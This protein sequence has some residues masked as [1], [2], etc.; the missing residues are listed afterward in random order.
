MKI[1]HASGVNEKEAIK[2]LLD[3]YRNTPHSSTGVAPS[4]MLFRDGMQ[5]IFPRQSASDREIQSARQRELEKKKSS[6]TKVNAGKF[7]IPSDFAVGD[8]VLVRNYQKT[9]KFEPTFL[10]DLY[11]VVEISEN[12]Q[13]LTLEDFTNGATLKRHPDDVK[14]YGGSAQQQLHNE[15]QQPSEQEVLK[16]Y[17]GRLSQVFQDYEDTFGNDSLELQS[18]A[19]PPRQRRDNPRYFNDDFVNT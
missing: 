13:C 16:E 7:R 1:A 11:I 5:S 9:R 19:R 6:Q 4:A 3:N 2:T 8:R 12:G 18:N 14:K 15:N 10:P 17:L